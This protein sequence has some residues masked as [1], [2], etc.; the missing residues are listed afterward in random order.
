MEEFYRMAATVDSIIP[1]QSTAFYMSFAAYSIAASML[2]DVAGESKDRPKACADIKRASELATVVDLNMARGGRE[3]P[4]N[5]AAILNAL[6]TQI[7][8]YIETTKK[9]LACK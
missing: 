4:A 2:Q 1:Q 3:N 7:K 6:N 9:Q 8:P 5:A